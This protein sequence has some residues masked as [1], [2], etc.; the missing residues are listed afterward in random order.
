[1]R[2]SFLVIPYALFPK[3]Y[4]GVRYK[5]KWVLLMVLAISPLKVGYYCQR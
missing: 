5:M 2:M 1:M 4:F 3:A